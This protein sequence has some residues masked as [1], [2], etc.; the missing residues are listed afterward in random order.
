LTKKVR[1]IA[2]M[3]VHNDASRYLQGL[4]IHLKRWVDG[5]VVLDNASTDETLDVLKQ[6][7]VVISWER[8]YENLWKQNEALMRRYLWQLTVKKNPD[9]ILAIDSDEFFEERIVG[10]IRGLINQDEYDA[11]DFRLFDFWD[12][13]CYRVDGQWN[14]WPRFNRFLVRYK[15]ELGAT[16]PN[17]PFHCGRWPLEYRKGL[18]VFQSD[19]RVKHLGWTRPKERMQKLK[20]Y[21]EKDLAM[22]GKVME[23]TL[24]VAFPQGQVRLEEWVEAEV[25]AFLAEEMM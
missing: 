23:H 4:L 2:M 6:E 17:L 3:P 5:V 13:Y 19:I 20:F 18:T 10:E 14:P 11:V 21:S 8:L 25:P 24:S 22:Y 1:L 15:P 7:S 16:W 9:W 12:D